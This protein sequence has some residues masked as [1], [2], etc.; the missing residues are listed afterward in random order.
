MNETLNV[1]EEYIYAIPEIDVQAFFNIN[2]N[3]NY[4]KSHL[5]NARALYY[6]FYATKQ[7]MRRDDI[8]SLRDYNYKPLGKYENNKEAFE[9]ISKGV[10]HLTKISNCNYPW[11]REVGI[12]MA[13]QIIPDIEGFLKHIRGYDE[14]M[15]FNRVYSYEKIFNYNNRIEKLIAKCQSYPIIVINYNL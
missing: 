2:S 10:A 11:A 4:P 8:N 1:M 15:E 5:I 3:L 7:Q 13:A 12:K 14:L 6:F 9:R